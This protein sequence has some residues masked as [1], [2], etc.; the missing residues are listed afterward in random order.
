MRGA[1][2]GSESVCQP[3]HKCAWKS[4]PSLG[5][6]PRVIQT[7][8]LQVFGTEQH[9][10]KHCSHSGSWIHRVFTR[11]VSFHSVLICCCWHLQG[12]GKTLSSLLFIAGSAIAKW[13]GRRR[14][15]VG[16][17]RGHVPGD[18]VKL[19]CCDVLGVGDR[20]TVQP[21]QGMCSVISAIMLKPFIFIWATLNI[22]KTAGWSSRRQVNKEE[23]HN[24]LQLKVSLC[25]RTSFSQWRKKSVCL[26]FLYMPY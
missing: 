18:T 9:Q 15:S 8:P 20:H 13:R 4:Q 10:R 3:G 14:G 11:G 23:Q 2:L 19:T 25:S 21:A 17:H 1:L 7:L 6:L 16:S 24:L 12:M 26:F 22:P 5:S